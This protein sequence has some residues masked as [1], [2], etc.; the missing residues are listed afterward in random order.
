MTI[1]S[2]SVRWMQTISAVHNQLMSIPGLSECVENEFEAEDV[3]IIYINAIRLQREEEITSCR[4]LSRPHS[5]KAIGLGTASSRHDISRSL[6]SLRAG[7]QIGEAPR[8]PSPVSHANLVFPV[9]ALPQT[10]LLPT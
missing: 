6:G 9:S 8:L 2:F 3:K 10:L 4:R 1:N 7:I 5:D